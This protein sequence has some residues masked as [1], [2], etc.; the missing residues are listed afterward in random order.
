VSLHRFGVLHHELNFGRA[1]VFI[2]I[3]PEGDPRAFAQRIRMANQM[4]SERTSFFQQQFQMTL[5]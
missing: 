4:A 1:I 2:R 3:E 5:F